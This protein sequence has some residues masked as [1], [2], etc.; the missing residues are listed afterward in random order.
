MGQRS[1]R[2]LAHD[3]LEAKRISVEAQVGLR[4]FARKRLLGREARG[5]DASGKG[6]LQQPGLE[7]GVGH[8]RG[9][10][11]PK[12]NEEEFE[13]AGVGL[14]MSLNQQAQAR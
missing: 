3:V 4:L 11:A 8:L 14:G 10:L 7:G 6:R 12:S 13:R 2:R 9:E 1:G 5:S